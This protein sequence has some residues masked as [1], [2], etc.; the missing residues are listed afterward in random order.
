ML[1][2]SEKVTGVAGD[3]TGAAGQRVVRR[4]GSG[5]RLWLSQV[6]DGVDPP[7]W[8]RAQAIKSCQRLVPGA[9]EDCVLRSRSRAIKRAEAA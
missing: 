7:G 1:F 4:T 2:R 9:A 6:I 5:L 3:T 8:D